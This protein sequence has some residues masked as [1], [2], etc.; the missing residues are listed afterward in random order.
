MPDYWCL[1]LGGLEQGEELKAGFSREIFEESGIKPK[2]GR[3]LFIQQIG[4]AEGY[5][6][7]EFFFLVENG[8]DF[9]NLDLSKASHA[10]MELLEMKF[11]DVENVPVL[12]EFLKHKIPTFIKEK[13]DLPIEFFT[14]KAV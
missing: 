1:L 13:F 11:L 7:P 14:V 5:N 6:Y 8:S 4:S 10:D 3:L 9:L 12:P 2:I